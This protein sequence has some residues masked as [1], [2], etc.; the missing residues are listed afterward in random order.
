MSSY[1]IIEDAYGRLVFYFIFYS[2]LFV[3]ICFDI[4]IK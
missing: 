1:Q 2:I 4:E 3:S